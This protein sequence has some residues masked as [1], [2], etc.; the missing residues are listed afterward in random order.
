MMKAE[1]IR[2]STIIKELERQITVIEKVL[3]RPEQSPVPDGF[4]DGYLE[5]LRDIKNSLEIPS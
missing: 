4:Y 3:T 1:M 2:K 5:A